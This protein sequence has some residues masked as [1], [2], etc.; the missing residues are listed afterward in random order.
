MNILRETTIYQSNIK[1][2]N[3]NPLQKNILNFSLH[4]SNFS[5]TFIQISNPAIPKFSRK[6]PRIQH[7]YSSW[8]RGSFFSFFGLFRRWTNFFKKKINVLDRVFK[9][10]LI[11]NHEEINNDHSKREKINDFLLRCLDKYQRKAS[12]L[13]SSVN[14]SKTGRDLIVRLHNNPK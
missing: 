6:Q 7:R 5:I 12:V 10:F 3:W 13:F 8:G 2:K 1:T 11:N 9:K 4:C 14:F